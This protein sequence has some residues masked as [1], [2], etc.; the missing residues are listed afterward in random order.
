VT[1]NKINEYL[2][3]KVRKKHFWRFLHVND[4]KYW[5]PNRENSLALKKL[6]EIFLIKKRK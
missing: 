2:T 6:R 5:W 4:N 3:T 1:K